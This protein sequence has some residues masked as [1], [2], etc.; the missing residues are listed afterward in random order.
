MIAQVCQFSEL[1]VGALFRLYNVRKK[2]K[3]VVWRK[4]VDVKEDSPPVD[5]AKRIADGTPAWFDRSTAISPVAE[6]A[7]YTL[8][9]LEQDWNKIFVIYRRAWEADEKACIAGLMDKDTFTRRSAIREQR[10]VSLRRRLERQ[11]L[12]VMA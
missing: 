5:N 4:T 2:G 6:Q 1:P 12:E 3:Y 11:V 10:Y 8:L 7:T 9:K